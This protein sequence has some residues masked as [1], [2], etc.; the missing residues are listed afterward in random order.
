[1]LPYGGGGMGL[2]RTLNYLTIVDTS[3][4]GAAQGLSV[5]LYTFDR[6]R[7]TIRLFHPMGAAGVDSLDSSEYTVTDVPATQS[8]IVEARGI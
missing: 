4:S 1:M 6:A 2:S 8:I 7:M 3:N 5:P